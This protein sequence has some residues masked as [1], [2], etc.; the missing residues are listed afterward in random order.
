MNTYIDVLHKIFL[1]ATEP[2]TGHDHRGPRTDHNHPRTDHD[3]HDDGAADTDIPRA[4]LRKSQWLFF[5]G[6]QNLHC[7]Q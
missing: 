2:A 3:Y 7:G 6:R 1:L 5:L 4:Q